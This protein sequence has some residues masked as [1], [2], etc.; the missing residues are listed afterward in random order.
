MVVE[1]EYGREVSHESW[2]YYPDDHPPRGL[3]PGDTRAALAPYLAHHVRRPPPRRVQTQQQPLCTVP[4]WPHRLGVPGVWR[5]VQVAAVRGRRHHVLHRWRPCPGAD[6]GCRPAVLHHRYGRLGAHAALHGRVVRSSCHPC[7][8][9][10]CKLSVCWRADNLWWSS[11]ENVIG[12]QPNPE[13]PRCLP[14]GFEVPGVPC[15]WLLRPHSTC[16][17]PLAPPQA[18]AG[19]WPPALH[20]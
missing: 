9:S 4:Q 5:L 19:G 13:A 8:W 15:L 7:S 6:A 10:R 12:Y 2:R 18:M 16:L 3:H 14:C 20:S 17:P 11:T 1:H